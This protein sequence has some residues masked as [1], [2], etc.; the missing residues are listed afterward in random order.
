MGLINIHQTSVH[1][2]LASE[3]DKTSKEHFGNAEKRT[4]A[5][6]WEARMCYA[7]PP[8]Q[9]L[10]YF[11]ATAIITSFLILYVNVQKLGGR[12]I[13]VVCEVMGSEPFNLILFSWTGPSLTLTTAI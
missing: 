8:P 6:K 10:E 5:T 9:L 2:P 12:L 1:F 13:R 7:V 4:Q 3:V 11:N